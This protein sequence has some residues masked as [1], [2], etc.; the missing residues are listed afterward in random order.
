MLVALAGLLALIAWI[1]LSSPSDPMRRESRTAAREAKPELGEL[2]PPIE[3]PAGPGRTPARVAPPVPPTV[4]LI[5]GAVTGP[6]G[7][8]AAGAEVYTARAE[9]VAILR[10]SLT[11]WGRVGKDG[12]FRVEAPPGSTD[13]LAWMPGALPAIVR[14][15]TVAAGAVVDVGTLHLA[16]GLAVTGQVVDTEGSPVEGVDVIAYRD[17]SMVSPALLPAREGL[18]AWGGRSR[19]DERGDFRLGG[20]SREPVLVVVEALR[21]RMEGDPVEA[22]PG[23]TGV[24][25]VVQEL[26]I[27]TGKVVTEIGSAG[28]PGATV[29]LDVRGPR[30]TH[31]K[32]VTTVESGRFSFDLSGEAYSSEKLRYDVLVSAEGYEDAKVTSLTIEDL[33]PEAKLR[34][35]LVRAPVRQP[36]RLRGRALYDTGE[37]F[38]GWI[39]ISFSVEGKAGQVY[40]VSTDD[41][42][43]FLVEGVPSGEY[44]LHTAPRRSLVLMETGKRLV[45]PPNGE[46]TT[47]FVFTR[48]G[49]VEVRITD[50]AGEVPEGALVRLLDGDGKPGEPYPAKTGV[51]VIQDVPPGMV[52]I[53]VGAPGHQDQEVAV[54]VTKGARTPVQGPSRGEA[55]RPAPAPRL[56]T[57]F[58]Y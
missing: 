30:G 36:G 13:V 49:D 28:V 48:G 44:V 37:P 7:E 1:T 40:R 12:R 26:R 18:S 15:V 53:R 47:E 6:A 21:Y 50:L 5:V 52:R 31:G 55:L 3:E 10:G 41:N 32:I 38:R 45:I 27:A 54:S 42:G 14:D 33:L 35:P 22:V 46:E 39:T 34:I 29:R 19:T 2:P 43:E 23:A 4:G 9:Q 17:E 20:L 8:P 58:S 16:A 25:I 11:S 56:G 57:P 24:R 51:V